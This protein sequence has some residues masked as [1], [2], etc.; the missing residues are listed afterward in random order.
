MEEYLG[1]VAPK[2]VELS[3]RL[4]AAV[5]SGQMTQRQAAAKLYEVVLQVSGGDAQIT[6][7]FVKLLCSQ[8]SYLYGE[9]W[10]LTHTYVLLVQS[11]ADDFGD[12]FYSGM[13][14]HTLGNVLGRQG[15]FQEAKQAYLASHAAFGTRYP[16]QAEVV[17]G[18][19]GG[20]AYSLG[21]Y[22]EAERLLRA[23]LSAASHRASVHNQLEWKLS[24]GNTLVFTSKNE[25]ALELLEDGLRQAR[26]AGK[27][28]HE[29][30]FL[31]GIANVYENLG[32]YD[33]CVRLHNEAVSISRRIG[34]KAS[35]LQDLRN[36]GNLQFR[37]NRYD[38]ALALYK[39]AY[40]LAVGLE[41][42]PHQASLLGD[43][44]KVYLRGGEVA[45]AI[46][47]LERAVEV[48]R[49]HGVQ[50]E[51]MRALGNLGGAYHLAGEFQKARAC[52]EESLPLSRRSG[53]LRS[54]TADLG[55]LSAV[56]RAEGDAGAALGYAEEALAVAERLQ[57]PTLIWRAEWRLA[58]C[59]RQVPAR[60]GE[61]WRHYERAM[62]TAETLRSHVR[63]EQDRIDF[64]SGHQYDLYEQAVSWLLDNGEVERAF[65]TAERFK[66]R[67]LFDVMAERATGELSQPE[68]AS[69][70]LSRARSAGAE[71]LVASYF[72]TRDETIL[73]LIAPGAEAVEHTRLPFGLEA[74]LSWFE[75]WFNLLPG[76]EGY[77]SPSLTLA[78][79]ERALEELDAALVRPLRERLRLCPQA[80]R[81]LVVPHR[82]LH[83]APIH[84]ARDPRTGLH[85]AEEAVVTYLPA[86]RLLK[87]PRPGAARDDLPVLAVG[88]PSTGAS[89]IR[90]ALSEAQ[91]VADLFGG[92]LLAGDAATVSA[93]VGHAGRSRII[94]LACH[95]AFDVQRPEKSYLLMAGNERLTAGAIGGMSLGNVE[96]VCMAACES[97]RARP[98]GVDEALGLTRA[99]LASDVAFVL[100]AQWQLDDDTSQEFMLD[101]YRR[102]REGS[103]IIDAFGAAERALI[104]RPAPYNDPRLWGPF[105]L[106]GFA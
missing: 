58:G 17:A 89:A 98:G 44:A 34:D 97:G 55:N 9:H 105:M 103:G 53:D 96:L 46:S 79:T 80:K 2:I 95:G 19:L 35:E 68:S 73:F 10:P 40:E 71:S 3:H 83:S 84:A 47:R 102:V 28:Y 36:F 1:S 54:L 7:A 52:H 64:Y 32:R 104:K 48:C 21:E 94:H 13:A 29:G 26:S 87:P 39:Q 63:A 92:R 90:G 49:E 59:L 67:L 93:F 31:T 30:A 4:A 61:V 45:T 24:L 11:V 37:F 57:D 15:R 99:W 38:A 78:E 51:L 12:P 56:A 60:H 82:F 100:G 88:E 42:K 41:H 27:P 22:E 81:V 75:R 33:D 16:E 91:A 72:M 65:E 74:H 76:S 5:S 66:S 106:T 8:A 101:F 62:D 25:E 70:L 6:E 43:I 77:E 14:A 69:Q 18:D 85:L 86:L 23:V 20:T 50:Y